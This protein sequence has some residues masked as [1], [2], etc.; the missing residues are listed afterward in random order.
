VYIY[1]KLITHLIMDNIVLK[2]LKQMKCVELTHQMILTN[3][4][5]QVIYCLS[6]MLYALCLIHTDLKIILLMSPEFI[7]LSDYKVPS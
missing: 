6:Y 5:V 4:I 7:E 3:C 2:Y 1:N